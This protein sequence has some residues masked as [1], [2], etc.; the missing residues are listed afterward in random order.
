MSIKVKVLMHSQGVRQNQELSQAIHGE[1]CP[2]VLW[3]T[4]IDKF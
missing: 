3:V 1:D 4:E 2:V